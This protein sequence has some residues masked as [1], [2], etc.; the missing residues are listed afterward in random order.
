M[1]EFSATG[2][3]AA[4]SQGSRERALDR[5][6][7]V[8]DFLHTHR[9]PVGAAELARSLGAPRSTVYSLV[10]SLTELGILESLEDGR[11][12]FGRRLYLWGLDYLR[13][14]PLAQRGREAV[15]S[16]SHET[17]ETAEMC[18]LQDGR[19]VIL[20]MCP[21]RRPFRI[22]SAVGLQIPLPWTASGRLLLSDIS[23]A[24]TDALLADDDFV[25]PDGTRME[26]EAFHDAIDEARQAGYAITSGLVDAFTKC[27][28]APVFGDHGRVAATLCFVVPMETPEPRVA[29]LLE[30]L[31]SR[32]ATLSAAA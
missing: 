14:N 21:G 5:M 15:D 24:A 26:R 27:L 30:L 1:Q 29:E 23:R 3:V 32:A 20:H 11:V 8:L 12:Y 18:I 7:Q 6:V 25:L 10:K 16:L 17:G 31:L 28:A 9:A 13:E 2:T 22:S 4:T 19:Y